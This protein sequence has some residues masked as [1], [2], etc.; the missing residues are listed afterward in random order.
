MQESKGTKKDIRWINYVRAICVIMI[1]YI[2][3]QEFF[4]FSI[5][6]LAKYIFP[7]YVNAF[8]FV[9]GY[10]M[11]KK[12][13]PFVSDDN[14]GEKGKQFLKNILFRLIIA[15]L[16]FS[17]IEFVPSCLFSSKKITI[18]GFLEKTICGN[19]YWF[20]SALVIAELIVYLLFLT[21]I[22]NIWF[23]FVSSIGLFIIGMLC[24][25]NGFLLFNVFEGNPW[26]FEKG[27]VSVI[28]L[29]LG[30]IF[31]KYESIFDRYLAKLPI[32]I[33]GLL[34][35]ISLL[36]LLN[37]HI[38]ILISLNSINV[39]GVMISTIGIILLVYLC[40]Y[41]KAINK[42]TNLLNAI[43][44]NTIGFYFVCGAIPKALT[45]ILP[46]FLPKSN[47]PYMLFGFIASFVLACI[48]VSL[49][50][51]FTPFLFDLRNGLKRTQK[52][53]NR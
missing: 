43:G 14:L 45:I 28:F 41:I 10:L 27:F 18:L 48:A 38:K 20:I 53:N 34:V 4:E 33:C 5:Q 9:S 8:F 21:K 35:Y 47:L 50:T 3:A 32:I 51:R 11:F 44:Q 52:I 29:V 42:P 49:M 16:I 7:V 40:K 39:L 46:K 6:G 12:L 30:G 26:H 22:K 17:I 1:Y 19:T 37:T 2:H 23:Y 25:N 13:F 36:S 31:W 15:S 24:C